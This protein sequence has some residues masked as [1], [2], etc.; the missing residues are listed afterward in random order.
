MIKRDSLPFACGLLLIGVLSVGM[1]GGC[2]DSSSTAA[3]ESSGSTAS[4]PIK[5]TPP[6]AKSD[7]TTTASNPSL[8]QIPME[9]KTDGYEYYGLG[10]SATMKMELRQGSEKSGL[11]GTQTIT[12]KEMKD[13]APIFTMEHGDGLAGLGSQE[14]RVEKDGIYTVA[15]TLAKVGA[16]DLEIPA[17]LDPG[18]TWKSHEEVDK[19]NSNTIEDDVYKVVGVQKVKTSVGQYDALLITSAGESKTTGGNSKAISSSK[20]HSEGWYVK[21]RGLVRLTIH[22]T[23]P[24]GKESD[25]SIEE[26]K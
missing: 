3:N 15:S 24:K 8:D 12:F 26:V 2:K 25:L 11:V 4:S 18:V 23:D 9:L 5:G 13:G 21:G 14:L 6:P 10:N 19:D 22:S 7:K 20:I 16:H 17:K 1:L